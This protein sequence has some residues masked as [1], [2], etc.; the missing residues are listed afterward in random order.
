[1]HATTRYVPGPPVGPAG[2]PAL[3]IDRGLVS[4]NDILIAETHSQR[5]HIDLADAVVA[6]GLASEED[7]F[8]TLASAAGLELID[9]AE[10]TSSELALRLVPERLARRHHVVP[11]RLDNRTL[12][13]VTCRPFNPEADSDLRFATG[14]RITFAVA[15]RTAVLDALARGYPKLRELDVL[16]ERLRTERPQVENSEP[17]GAETSSTVIELCNHIIGRAVEVGA[18]DV[19]IECGSEGAT[20]RLR[21]CGVLEPVLTLPA[22]VSHPI[23]NRFKIMARA[24]IALRN[25]PQDGAFRLKVNGRPTDVRLSTL[26][27]STG[28]KIVM[29]VIDSHSPLQSLEALGYDEDTL[30]RLQ[31]ALTRPDGLVLVTGP[32]GCGKTTALYAAVGH[33]RTGRTNI[34]SVEDPVERVVGGVTQIPVNGKAGNTFPAVLRS[35]LRQDPNIIMVG[36]I[37]DAEV[38]QI[39]GQAAYTG[40]L[41]LSSVHTVDTATA[42][43]RLTNLGLEPFKVAECLSAILA[44]RLLRTL[45]P[46]CK[47]VHDQLEARRRGAEHHI[48]VATAS[49]GPGCP[50]CKD[51][52]YV[53]RVPIAELLTPSDEL[54]DAIVRGATAHEIRSAMRASGTRTMRDRA[55]EL[56]ADGLTSIEEVNRVL[57]AD[58]EGAHAKTHD[59]PRVLVT[60]DEPIT[61]MLVKLLLER[62]NFEVLEA[63]NGE[64]AVEIAIREHPDLLLIDLNMPQMDGYEAIAR[65]RRD[66]SLATLPIIVLTSE[67]GPGVEKRVL[68]LGADDYI[69]KPFDPTV[70][71]SRVNAVFRRL[72]VMAA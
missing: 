63:A 62:E 39:V 16:A 60:D 21:V 45:C 14:R 53:G 56:V 49:A 26:P 28:E 24:D 25:R 47:R 40:H 34:V 15:T 6:L 59:K 3:L 8:A 70:L 66:F 72:K 36:E 4:R 27:T 11:L 1:V 46:H 30:V 65:L 5:E 13:C 67:E 41:V 43:T 50:H 23:R 54:R 7:C 71:L 35:M 9:L 18:S 64:Q 51:T 58:D 17:A 2:F 10:A 20:V 69:L 52:G 22:A 68:Q 32:T 29:R 61:R 44:Q 19:H 33:L 42:I 38:A 55:L 48:K 57:A 12:T 37:R 31:R